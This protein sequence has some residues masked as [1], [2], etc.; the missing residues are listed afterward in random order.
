MTK[1]ACD[2]PVYSLHSSDVADECHPTSRQSISAFIVCKNEESNIRRCLES[3]SW[4]DE[5]VIVD[6]GSTDRTIDICREFSKLIYH[7][8]WLGYVQQKQYGLSRCTKE[9]IFNLDA[10]EVVTPELR[11]SIEGVLAS[12]CGEYNGFECLRVVFYLGRWWR[13]GG[14]Y[15]EYRLRL[16]RR[17]QTTW[18]GQDPHEH[19]IVP[20][21]TPRLTGELQHFT[22]EKIEHQIR[23]LNAHSTAA[24]R[25]LYRA[26]K[27]WSLARQLGNPLARFFKFYI[28]K[29]G[30]LDGVPGLVVAVME[31]TYT[32]LKYAKLW[33]LETFGAE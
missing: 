15:P 21:P 4:C 30:F 13:R 18:G 14:W 6:S 10:D 17:E 12:D 9:W 25:S 20:G 22:Y 5:I 28:A 16:C 29:R 3:I 8:E 23:S 7:H 19:A 26:G 24:A 31:A 33:E 27:K 11:A 1:D 2:S 32:F